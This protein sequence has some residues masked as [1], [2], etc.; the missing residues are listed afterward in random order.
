MEEGA[1]IRASTN[2]MAVA[3]LVLGILWLGGIGAVLALI[4]GTK[5]KKQID[6]SNGA[7]GGRGIANAGVVLGIV[8]IVG[9]VIY[10]ALIIIAATHSSGAPAY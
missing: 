2:G 5:A 9:A 10:W 4:F 1:V 8:G 6:W 7:Q 3:S